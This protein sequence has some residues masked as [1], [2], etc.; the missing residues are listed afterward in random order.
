MKWSTV[1]DLESCIGCQAC[2]VACKA[3]FG[4]PPGPGRITVKTMEEGVFPDTVRSHQ[5]NRCVQCSS[6]PCVSICPTGALRRRPDGVVALD[7]NACL[8][9]SA[10]AVA[11]PFDAISLNA[12]TGLA[13]K[14]DLCAHR[15]DQGLEPACAAACPTR[16]IQVGDVDNPDHPV[17]VRIAAGGLGVRRPEL[18]VGPALRYHGARPAG[19]TPLKA[20][21]PAGGILQSTEQAEL[22]PPAPGA[23]ALVVAGDGRSPTPWGPRTALL[24]WT[25]NIAAGVA[26]V[27]ALGVVLGVLPADSALWRLLS[28]LLLGVYLVGSLALATTQVSH[29]GRL[30]LLW[31]RPNL[32][33]PVARTAMASAALGV[34][35]LLQGLSTL[36]GFPLERVL[37]L[38]ALALSVALPLDGALLLRQCRGRTLWTG[39]LSAPR[40]LFGAAL[41]GAAM[42]SPFAGVLSAGLSLGLSAAVAVSAV[43]WLPLALGEVL[44]PLSGPDARLA[45]GELRRGSLRGFFI[46]GVALT[47]TGLTAPLLGALTTP[48]V[49][50]GLLLYEHAWIQAGQTAPQG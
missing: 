15:L 32:R 9:C 20:A 41:A 46:A 18:N 13:D 8:G 31:I 43:G 29:P 7:A 44:R 24:F 36:I 21:R 27:P 28:P 25:R 39:P 2:A 11:C 3:E 5:V 48:A 17:A 42:L 14:C 12:D 45:A 1:I 6:A 33:S 22:V 30:R 23:T 40:A 4:L 35:M 47:A 34:V 38:P 50:A 37:L 19:L 26:L 10:C 16:A 49:L